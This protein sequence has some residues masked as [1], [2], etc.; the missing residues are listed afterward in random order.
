VKTRADDAGLLRLRNRVADLP[1]ACRQIDT[2][3]R[4]DITAA[5]LIRL[6]RQRR[7]IFH[8]NGRELRE[9]LRILDRL[10]QR[11]VAHVGRRRRAAALADPDGD[12]RADALPPAARQKCV[13]REPEMRI[14][15]AL[16]DRDRIVRGDIAEKLLRDRA[17]GRFG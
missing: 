5:W 13:R 9:R 7:Q 8:V 3:G 2:S 12:A 1:R 4:L 15:L 16:H 17:R 11:R 14:V 10:L 6:L